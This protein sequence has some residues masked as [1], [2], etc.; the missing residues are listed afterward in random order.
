MPYFLFKFF[1]N[2]TV[3]SIES[4]PKF[5]DAR[6]RVR[7]LRMQLT[8]ADNCEIKMVHAPNEGAGAKLLMTER[9][10]IPMGDD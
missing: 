10:A 2:R 9:E 4:H 1:P 7:E 8:V 3:E 6:D 5:R